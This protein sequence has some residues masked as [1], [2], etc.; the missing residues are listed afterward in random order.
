VPG[1][2]IQQHVIFLYCFI[3]ALSLSFILSRSGCPW[4]ALFV[5][6]KGIWGGTRFNYPAGCSSVFFYS[7]FRVIFIS[8]T[9]C[10]EIDIPPF[11]RGGG[12][13]GVVVFLL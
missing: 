5:V 3:P 10:V 8:L 12:G 9:P 13:W 4:F 2:I 7:I 11:F 6:Q 1:S